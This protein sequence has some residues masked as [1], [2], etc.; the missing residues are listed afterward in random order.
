[1]LQAL[2]SVAQS[3]P[4]PRPLASTVPPGSRKGG[5]ASASFMS[6]PRY[7][8]GSEGIHI[9]FLDGGNLPALSRSTTRVLLRAGPAEFR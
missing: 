6:A 8:G 7:G 5:R 2:A 4:A 3:S 9:R 1:V